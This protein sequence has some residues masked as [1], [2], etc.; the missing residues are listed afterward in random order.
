MK[1][2]YSLL[3]GVAL[4]SSAQVFAQSPR[5]VFVE[6]AT[7]ASCPPCATMN[8]PLMNVVNTNDDKVIFMAYQVWWP[9]FDQMYLDNPADVNHRIGTYYPDVLGA[10]NIVIQ[11]SLGGGTGNTTSLT[12][13]VINSTYAETSEF[14]LTVNAE[15][16]DGE[17]L[18]TGMV[19]ATSDI[20]G[21]LKLHLVLTEG[22]IHSTQ[23]TGG[24]N[25]ET[26]YHHV[27]KKFLPGVSGIELSATWVAG[28]TYVIDE[29]Y[30]LENLMI[31][32]YDDLEVIAFIQN[33]D[34]KFVH[35][36]AKDGEVNMTLNYEFNAA[37][38]GISG[39]PSSLCPGEQTLSP[40]VK[41]FNG[42]SG[43]LTSADIVYSVNGGTPQTYNWTGSLDSLTY[44]YVA[45][46]PISFTASDVNETE[47]SVAVE[48]PN[49]ETDG[50]TDDNTSELSVEVAP[51]SQ[52]NVEVEIKTDAYGD[53][54]YWQIRD[55]DGSVIAEGGNPNVGLDNV[56]T[57]AFPPPFSSLSYANNSTNTH[58][59]G[60]PAGTYCFT[61]HITDFFGD[62]LLGTGG[63]TV[64]DSDGDIMFSDTENFAVE[65]EK[66]FSG[67][68]F[69]GLNESELADALTVGPNPVNDILSVG[70]SLIDESN[71]TID[72]HDAIGKVVYSENK[73]N[74]SGSSITQIDLSDFSAGIYYVKITA[75]SVSTAKKVIVVR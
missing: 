75:G 38:Q 12:Q 39:T 65:S 15:F 74:I 43:V 1:K 37:L 23:A 16:V 6:E 14:D 18:V 31:Y 55:G 41:L 24:T 32:N 63:Y 70:L 3:I 60:I 8:P 54:T 29:V 42:G 56:G 2:I 20:S 7:Q 67:T 51:N 22:T 9:G 11:G 21:D 17:L 44:E 61:F 48:N 71:V 66:D 10:P 62:G 69:V 50:L 49:G 13:S 28:D 5:M 30:T 36:A 47:I 64:R 33:D 46:D 52:S 58:E 27:M 34:D 35:Q 19:E 57:G 26:E 53:E 68:G 72:I 73:G 59:V 25:G 4:M 40:T 45:L